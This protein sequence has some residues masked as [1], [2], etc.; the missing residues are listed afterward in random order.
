MAKDYP[1]LLE[2]DYNNADDKQSFEELVTFGDKTDLPFFY[3]KS[4]VIDLGILACE[5]IQSERELNRNRRPSL[6]K[7]KDENAKAA[8]RNIFDNL[9][10]HEA[11]IEVDRG[12]FKELPLELIIP[13]VTRNNIDLEILERSVTRNP[14]PLRRVHNPNPWQSMPSYADE[15]GQPGGAQPGGGAHA[16]GQGSGS[17]HGSGG[18][19]G[20]QGSGPRRISGPSSAT[21]SPR[22]RGSPYERPR[23]D[24][25][26]GNERRGGDTSGSRSQLHFT[27]T[28]GDSSSQ[29]HN[30]V[31]PPQV[32]INQGRNN[33]NVD[34]DD[35]LPNRRRNR[36]AKDRRT[37]SLSTNVHKRGSRYTGSST[38]DVTPHIPRRNRKPTPSSATLDSATL[39]SATLEGGI[40]SLH[41]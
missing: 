30:V 18:R 41:L 9:A 10:F 20:G 29:R 25:R 8:Y 11:F 19:S 26:R 32:P 39:D 16:G 6:A 5:I 21:D 34:D 38:L 7:K 23:G 1:Q 36:P 2:F 22:N 28:E 17:R 24:E 3:L 37:M 4:V 27:P 14:P 12:I 40:G 33:L 15:G 35:D 13:R 31:P